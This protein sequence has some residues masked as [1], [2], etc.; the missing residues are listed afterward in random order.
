M[1]FRERKDRLQVAD[2]PD[3]VGDDVLGEEDAV[4]RAG[5]DADTKRF[6]I[7][8]A[9]QREQAADADQC[10]AEA[11]L[12]RHELGGDQDQQRESLAA[13]RHLGIDDADR[14]ERDDVLERELEA[15]E[16]FALVGIQLE[17]A[18]TPHRPRVD[19]QADA[20]RRLERKGDVRH[21]EIAAALREADERAQADAIDDGRERPELGR[22]LRGEHDRDRGRGRPESDRHVEPADLHD[23]QID[24]QRDE[25]FDAAL[26]LKAEAI[27]RIPVGGD[28]ERRIQMHAGEQ[29][30]N[31]AVALGEVDDEPAVFDAELDGGRHL[32]A[33][34][35]EIRR[36]ADA[37]ANAFRRELR[38]AGHAQ[39]DDRVA[40]RFLGGQPETEIE[41]HRA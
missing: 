29:R 4:D 30:L 22:E 12:N 21:S 9:V 2:D 36:D 40:R 15:A 33:S 1:G 16:V 19:R 18:A 41:R 14:L 7:E 11:E 35:V 38:A 23:R 13:V 39:Q 8:R 24:L 37:T 25:D 20:A 34:R 26:S 32:A 3:D 28:A 10:E 17:E 6:L 27:F 31:E 5:P